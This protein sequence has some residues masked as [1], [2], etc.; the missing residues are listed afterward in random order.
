MFFA[1]IRQWWRNRTLARRA[2]RHPGYASGGFVGNGDLR[3]SPIYS[4]NCGLSHAAKPPFM[5]QGD[6]PDNEPPR[7]AFPASVCFINVL[8]PCG[9]ER[10]IENPATD[11]EFV[12]AVSR[13][14]FSFRDDGG[15]SSPASSHESCTSSDSGSSY[16]S[17]SSSDSGGC[18]SSG[19]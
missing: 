10:K 18:S 6:F 17:G 13:S 15:E 5:Q 8:D 9:I 7:P 3:R 19:D 16:D 4:Q 12:A 14:N 2:R 11:A 1:R